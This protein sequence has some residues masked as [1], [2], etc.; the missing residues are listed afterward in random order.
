MNTLLIWMHGLIWKWDCQKDKT[1]DKHVQE[2][3]NRDKEHWI[4]N[5]GERCC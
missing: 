5:I 1:I 3:V 2:Q 4:K